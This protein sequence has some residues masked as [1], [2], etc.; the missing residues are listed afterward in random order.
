[1]ED[2]HSKWS[3]DGVLTIE[4]VLPKQIESAKTKS[5]E[6][7]IPIEHGSGQETKNITEGADAAGK[8]AAGLGA[9]TSSSTTTTKEKK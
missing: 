3:E 2:L 9:D 8:A 7:E 5:K 6:R 4:A 1:M